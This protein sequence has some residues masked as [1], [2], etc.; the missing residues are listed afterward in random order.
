MANL[1]NITAPGTY[2][3]GVIDATGYDDAINIA[4]SDV[5]VYATSISN[6]GNVG[7]NVT[8]GQAVTGATPKGNVHIYVDLVK[9]CGFHGYQCN[10]MWKDVWFHN[11]HSVANGVGIKGSHGFTSYSGADQF[12]WT[13]V[14][15][16]V[17]TP[18]TEWRVELTDEN[19]AVIRV[20][21]RAVRVLDNSE[22]FLSGDYLHI[23]TDPTSFT[24]SQCNAP[25]HQCTNVN[26][27]DCVSEGTLDADGLEGHGFAFDGWSRD[28]IIDGCRSINNVGYGLSALGSMNCR[29]KGG[30]VFSGNTKGDIWLGANAVD[31]TLDPDTVYTNYTKQTAVYPKTDTPFLMVP[32]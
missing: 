2:R 3:Y 17:V 7:V 19:K 4:S 18:D 13:I 26:F 28:C 22:W 32:G 27:V 12:D 8:N 31:I 6:A 10:G 9:N 20:I 14:P 11:G 30:S 16:E 15:W 21:D 25:T 5:T 1:Y 24:G 29:V 23:T